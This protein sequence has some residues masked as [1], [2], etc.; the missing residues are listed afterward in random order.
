MVLV[1]RSIEPL[2]SN[3][4]FKSKIIVIYGPRQVGKTTLA[5]TL[6]I[7]HGDAK[8]YYNCDLIPVREVLEKQDPKLLRQYVGDTK[9]FVLDEAQQV[10]DIG[11]VLKIFH[12]TYPDVQII[13]TGSSSFDLANK[14]NEPLTGRVLEFILY[15]FSLHEVTDGMG[16]NNFDI[17]NKLEILM[18]FGS[19]PDIYLAENQNKK[20]TLLSTLASNYLYKDVLMFENLRKPDLLLKLLKLLA[21]QIGGEVSTHE[22][23]TKLG[24][25]TGT[26]TRYLDLLEKSFVIFQLKPFSG[27]LRN[28]IGRKSKI[29]F[30]DL[31][32]RNILIDRVA[33][34]DLRDDIG[35][36]WENF[37]L[38]ERLKYNQRHEH[39]RNMYFW[40]THAGKEIDCIEEY[41]GKLHGYEFKWGDAKYRK[42]QEFLDAYEGS[43]IEIINKGSWREFLLS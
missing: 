1:K 6:L 12:D 35:G 7:R 5:K 37:C 18:R 34:L 21:L 16:V 4:L 22:L 9:L 14:L 40:R 17:E 11:K 2:I 29:F 20:E 39:H 27:N 10:R 24:V 32:I 42:P 31:G 43:S 13:A 33:A 41:E 23:A 19:Y 28:E 26:I 15:P 36:L 38:V 3:W 30:Y 8:D 25:G